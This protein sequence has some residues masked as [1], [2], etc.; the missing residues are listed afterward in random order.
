MEVNQ[1]PKYRMRETC[2]AAKIGYIERLPGRGANLR[3]VGGGV[4]K[5]SEDFLIGHPA[6]VGDY[7]VVRKNNERLIWPGG[8]FERVFEAVE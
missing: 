4:F 3:F 7:L 5:V 1:L 6:K 2:R 8:G